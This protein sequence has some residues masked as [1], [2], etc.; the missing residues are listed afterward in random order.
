MTAAHGQLESQLRQTQTRSERAESEL[1]LAHDEQVLRLLLFSLLFFASS[2][3][4]TASLSSL[5]PHH[6]TS[7]TFPAPF[8]QPP[9]LSLPL[10]S[11]SSSLTSNNALDEQFNAEQLMEGSLKALR[12]RNS[13]LQRQNGDLV[14]VNARLEKRLADAD[15][16]VRVFFCRDACLPASLFFF[17]PSLLLL[18]SSL[19][20]HSRISARAPASGE[21]AIVAPRP[22]LDP[23]HRPG[24]LSFCA[25][26]LAL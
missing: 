2:N 20:R 1:E 16:Q 25:H 7:S 15:S 12:R 14:A 5:S 13:E 17:L 4:C 22:G 19:P 9:A 23:L 11:R 3:T 18:G 24:S 26:C 8:L 10:V 6:P 21:A